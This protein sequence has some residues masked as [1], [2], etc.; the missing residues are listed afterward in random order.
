MDEAQRRDQPERLHER[1]ASRIGEKDHQHDAALREQ[2]RKRPALT[3]REREER[4][5]IG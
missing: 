5:P 2:D 1:D 4:W 3:R